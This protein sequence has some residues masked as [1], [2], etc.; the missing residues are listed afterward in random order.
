MTKGA[1]ICIY[2]GTTA[3]ITSNNFK[4]MN[5]P[6]VSTSTGGE[7]VN[8]A[9][10]GNNTLTIFFSNSYNQ[11]APV[12]IP[13]TAP[14]DTEDCNEFTIIAFPITSTS[15]SMNV[16]VS[17]GFLDIAITKDDEVSSVDVYIR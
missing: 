14:A 9:Y 16:A 8:V 5:I 13:V 3:T 6:T 12:I 10:D 2:R 15:Y 7:P 11:T 4:N 1:P 17:D